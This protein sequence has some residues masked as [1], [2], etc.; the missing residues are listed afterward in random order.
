MV[1]DLVLDLVLDNDARRAPADAF[2]GPHGHITALGSCWELIYACT[3]L[4][5][6]D[7]AA[8]VTPG[9]RWNGRLALKYTGSS[10]GVQLGAMR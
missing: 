9:A 2:A 3:L 5:D 1:L 10:E 7:S 8:A 6:N 4:A